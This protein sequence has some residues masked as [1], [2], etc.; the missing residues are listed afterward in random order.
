MPAEARPLP[1]R[2]LAITEAAYG[3]DHPDV[4][5]DLNNLAGSCRTWGSRRRPGRCQNGRWP[6]TRRPTARTT[7]TS[8]P[9]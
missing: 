5:T 7:P 9:A 6:S 4:A 1:E 3:P 2:A 8:P